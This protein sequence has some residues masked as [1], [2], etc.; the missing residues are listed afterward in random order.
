[1]LDVNAGR[2]ALVNACGSLALER[3]VAG[4][5]S[6]MVAWYSRLTGVPVPLGPVVPYTT[7]WSISFQELSRP[8]VGEVDGVSD[9]YMNVATKKNDPPVGGDSTMAS[10]SSTP[11]S[12]H[13]SVP[14]WAPFQLAVAWL[15]LPAS[16]VQKLA[17]AMH[18]ACRSF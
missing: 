3:G 11:Y 4:S 2:V 14:A 17:F 1:M 5:D 6:N 12:M 9:P 13:P 18:G 15:L 16:L 10:V 7:P 8:Y